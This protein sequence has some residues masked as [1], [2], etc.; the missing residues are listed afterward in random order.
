MSTYAIQTD[1]SCM[2]NPGEMGIGIVIYENGNIKDTISEYVGEGTNNIAE[3]SALIRGLEEVKRLKRSEDRIEV[4]LDSLLIFKQ[5]NGEWEVKKQEL[6]PL[7]ERGKELIKEIGDIIIIWIGREENGIADR[8][9]KEAIWLK[10]F[11]EGE[12][13][14]DEISIR[15]KG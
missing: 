1:G 3:Y 6:N 2:P 13:M 7:C 15:P 5:I 9:A 12:E 10:R 11:N 14:R 8:M 4:F